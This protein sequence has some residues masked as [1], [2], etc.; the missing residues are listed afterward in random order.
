MTAEATNFKCSKARSH[1]TPAAVEI[2][3]HLHP[4]GRALVARS[5]ELLLRSLRQHKGARRTISRITGLEQQQEKAEQVASCDDLLEEDEMQKLP[6]WIPHPRTGIYFP[7][8]HERVMDKVPD[9][10]ASLSET[11]WFR[12]SHG[13]DKPD[14]DLCRTQT[15]AN[16][17][18]GS[19]TWADLRL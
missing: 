16:Y 4:M 5:T 15:P 14:P 8:G 1:L 13:V 17:D 2:T 9:N 18:V 10:A 19:T 6:V 7:R 3:E 12:S 11:C